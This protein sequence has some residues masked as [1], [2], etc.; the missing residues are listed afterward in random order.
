MSMHTLPVIDHQRIVA[1]DGP[2]A[3]GKS[4]VARIVA[5]RL[6]ALLFDTGALYRAVAL[7]A[8]R[9]NVSPD[10]TE[11]LAS[12]ARDADI[13][14]GPPSVQDGR[15]YDIWLDGDDV[16]WEARGADVG[17]VVSHIAEHAAV[18]AALLPLQRRIAGLGPVVMVGRD[19][20]T[21]VVPDAGLKVYLDASPHER[22]RRRYRE[23]LSRGDSPSYEDV[24]DETLQRDAIDSGRRTAPLR[25]APDAV[26]LSTDNLTIEDVVTAI[27]E[28]AR[29]RVANSSEAHWPR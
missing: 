2:A 24:L 3:A 6:G 11:A 26:Q 8:L 21:V 7:A 16:T 20:G 14:I 25:A 12:I 9:A 19:I 22:A 4:T 23:A 5:D 13:L 1:I 17:A 27:D 29:D 28:L 10:D 15:L 18:R